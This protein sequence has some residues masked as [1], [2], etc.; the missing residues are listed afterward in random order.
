MSLN[1]I[2]FLNLIRFFSHRRLADVFRVADALKKTKISN[3]MLSSLSL[4]FWH[5][6][7]GS[8]LT[9]IKQ[10]SLSERNLFFPSTYASKPTYVPRLRLYFSSVTFY[11]TGPWCF[12][13]SPFLH[14]F[15]SSFR[16]LL[17]YIS[18]PCF[19]IAA[20]FLIRFYFFSS[21]HVFIMTVLFRNISEIAGSVWKL[22]PC[23]AI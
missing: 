16:I 15:N 21:L 4:I 17:P 20:I 10:P 6:K 11:F 13:T 12:L 5:G 3:I 8:V 1:F 14:I 18:P 9:V 19:F 22:G 23:A 7:R 2:Y